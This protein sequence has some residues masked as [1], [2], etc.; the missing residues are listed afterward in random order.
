MA[1]SGSN[2][3]SRVPWPAWAG[4][5][6]LLHAGALLIGMPTIVR[7]DT[8]PSNS[9]DIPVTLIDEGDLPTATPVT[10][11]QTVPVP[12]QSAQQPTALG[13]RTPVIEP[14][15]NN[16]TAAQQTPQPD[17]TATPPNI[18][19]PVNE[20]PAKPVNKPDT[21]DEPQNPGRPATPP[22]TDGQK[23]NEPSEPAGVGEISMSIVGISTVPPGTPG[24]WP[25]ILPTLKSS[26]TLNISSHTCNDALPAG[27][28]TLGLLIGADGSVIQ[29]LAPP[30]QTSISA[31]TASCLLTHAL[32]INPSALQ[33]TPAYTGQNPIATDRMQ[34]TVQF[35]TG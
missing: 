34:L 32:S 3:L 16:Q 9:I 24:D 20:P 6:L 1:D 13:G 29:T 31:Q 23:P 8:P 2:K 11:S 22:A 35:Y 27:E 30:D 5:S 17:R 25:D 15:A 18:N 26:S 7:I 10:P 14:Q 28:V 21:S 33:F 12:E 19:Q 4:A